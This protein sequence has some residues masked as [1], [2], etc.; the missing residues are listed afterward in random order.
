MFRY[1]LPSGVEA[2]VPTAAN[3]AG[4]VP[5]FEYWQA[6]PPRVGHG[7]TQP[8]PETPAAYGCPEVVHEPIEASCLV[9]PVPQLT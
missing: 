3:V 8:Y 7:Q 9:L 1:Q 4:G 6:S 5:W 2:F